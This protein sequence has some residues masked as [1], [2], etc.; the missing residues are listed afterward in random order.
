MKFISTTEAGRK[1]GLSS[2][3]VA[4]LCTEGRIPDAQKVGNT[5]MLP[6]DAGKPSDARIKS[7]KYLKSLQIK[8]QVLFRKNIKKF[9]QKKRVQQ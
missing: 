3:R 8:S 4:V 1:W 9:M 7:G 2:R 5:W 6:E